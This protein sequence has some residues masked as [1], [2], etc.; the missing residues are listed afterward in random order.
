MKKVKEI[1]GK[2]RAHCS[3]PDSSCMDCNDGGCNTSIEGNDG[4]GKDGSSNDESEG[5]MSSSMKKQEDHSNTEGTEK[6]DE[7][8]IIDTTLHCPQDTPIGFQVI[9]GSNTPMQYICIHSLE[10]HSPAFNCGLFREG[11][12]L[13]MVGDTCLIGTTREQARLVLQQAH[14]TV[15]IIAQRKLHSKVTTPQD[16]PES[17]QERLIAQTTSSQE[18]T[19]KGKEKAVR[20]APVRMLVVNLRPGPGEALGIAITGGVNDPY[21]K[22]IHVS[23]THE[24][25]SQ[26]CSDYYS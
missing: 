10:P 2:K 7:D 16:F 23:E 1:K 19:G 15:R 18:A 3:S 4:S 26:P 21:L 6:Q 11:D 5:S 25:F 24:H 8:G 13:V 20:A 9:G 17:N 22:N 14:S 12:Q